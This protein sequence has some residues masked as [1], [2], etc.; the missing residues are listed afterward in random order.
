MQ[1]SFALNGK[2]LGVAFSDV[3]LWETHLVYFPAVSLSQGEACLVNFGARPFMFPVEGFRP[4]QRPPPAY[5]CAQATLV[6]SAIEKLVLVCSLQRLP[7]D[8]RSLAQVALDIRADTILM[9]HHL[10]ACL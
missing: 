3:K 5:L 4:L 1:V 10:S 9:C 8:L 2:Q 7:G 6:T